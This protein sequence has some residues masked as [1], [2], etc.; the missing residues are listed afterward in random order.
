MFFNYFNVASEVLACILRAIGAC[1]I[2]LF[3]AG[4]LA[5]VALS[6]HDGLILILGL[7]AA[8]MAVIMAVVAAFAEL[9]QVVEEVRSFRSWRAAIQNS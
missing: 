8:G 4:F 1:T 3:I 9:E 5:F 6:M 2:M 7:M